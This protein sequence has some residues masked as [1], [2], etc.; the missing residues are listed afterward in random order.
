M[1][2]RTSIYL[3][4]DVA[5]AL[6]SSGETGSAVLRRGLGMERPDEAM[7]RLASQTAMLDVADRLGE[8]LERLRGDLAE[9]LRVI[10]REEARAA[11]REAAGGWS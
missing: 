3:P 2:K 7:A 1:G 4:D 6:E 10:V 9:D 5:E 11:V 8:A